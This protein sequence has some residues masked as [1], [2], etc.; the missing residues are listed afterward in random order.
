MGISEMY[1]SR[2]CQDGLYVPLLF[3][4]LKVTGDGN[5]VYALNDINGSSIGAYQLN[6]V[7]GCLTTC[8][9]LQLLHLQFG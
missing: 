2:N 6:H 8:Y 1:A 9:V 7:I 4:A 3:D 5:L